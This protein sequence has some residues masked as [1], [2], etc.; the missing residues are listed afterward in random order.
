MESCSPSASRN[1]SSLRTLS[2]PLP[3]PSPPPF[4]SAA[5]QPRRFNLRP[6][7]LSHGLEIGSLFSTICCLCGVRGAAGADLKF[8]PSVSPCWSRARQAALHLRLSELLRTMDSCAVSSALLLAGLLC[9]AALSHF[10]TGESRFPVSA[11]S[12]GSS[13]SESVGALRGARRCFPVLSLVSARLG[14]DLLRSP[15]GTRPV[16]DQLPCE[17][18]LNTCLRTEAR[19]RMRVVPQEPAASR[20]GRC[21]FGSVSCEFT[22][23]HNFK[24]PH[25]PSWM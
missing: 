23:L 7:F 13:A 15:G 11:A 18:S 24:P 2:P 10:D 9:S 17:P 1:R 25:S 12:L 5:S 16:P 8:S 22:F 20:G 21:R 6:C 14:R 3:P 4:P 19:A